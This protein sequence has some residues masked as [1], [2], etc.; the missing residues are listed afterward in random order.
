M[1]DRNFVPTSFELKRPY[2]GEL[3]IVD[4]AHLRIVPTGASL[5]CGPSLFRR[6]GLDF[7]TTAATEQEGMR[8][9]WQNGLY[10]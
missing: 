10:G 6:K 2:I 1:Q 8:A 4:V 9:V 5:I 7:G 3:A